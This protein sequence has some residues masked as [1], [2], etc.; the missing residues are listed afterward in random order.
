[1]QNP[2]DIEV[3]VLLSFDYMRYRVTLLSAPRLILLGFFVLIL[4]IAVIL[5][6][7]FIGIAPGI[8]TAVIIGY[9]GYIVMRFIYKQLSTYLETS[10]DGVVICLYGEEKLTYKWDQFMLSGLCTQENGEKSLFLYT[11]S[12]DKLIEIPQEFEGF[13]Q[14]QEELQQRL[15]FQKLSVRTG[16]SIRDRIREIS[17]NS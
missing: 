12:S 8:I 4:C 11:E 7:I 1:M 6:F 17:E 10:T 5:I 13:P 15:V 2:F 3:L 14:L 9:L 16:E